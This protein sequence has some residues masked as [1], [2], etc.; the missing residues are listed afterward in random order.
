MET[1]VM[2]QWSGFG[3]S[4]SSESLVCHGLLFGISV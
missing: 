1:Q 2:E 3:E 4:L